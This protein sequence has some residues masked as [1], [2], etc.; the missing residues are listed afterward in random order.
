ME[1]CFLKKKDTDRL[2]KQAESVSKAKMPAC[3]E[4][5]IAVR[6]NE[7]VARSCEEDRVNEEVP[8]QDQ[9]LRELI[10]AIRGT[11]VIGQIVKCRAGSISRKDLNGLM[12]SIVDAHGRVL[13]AFL[14][15]F[16]SDGA[17][18]EIVSWVS[19]KL[20]KRMGGV[21]EIELRH[22]AT[23]LFWTINYFT[24]LGIVFR[25]IQ[26]VGSDKLLGELEKICIDYK[27]PMTDIVI[28]GAEMWFAKQLDVKRIYE[29]FDNTTGISRWILQQL[30][31][32]YCATHKLDYKTRQQIGTR[33]E[34]GVTTGI[35]SIE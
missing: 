20:R 8:E 19:E 26:T 22:H 12:R 3:L 11:E 33:L 27:S 10:T 30:V 2:D 6:R 31:A 35:K 1:A 34:I 14:S 18:A 13:S 4:S 15:T 24:I 29:I 32:R 23:R 17:K 16:D 7:L 9:F 28:V 5:P 21:S 25:C